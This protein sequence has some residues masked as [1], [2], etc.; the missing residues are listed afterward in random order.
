VSP[1]L[2]FIGISCNNPPTHLIL[3]LLASRLT[4]WT[5][6]STPCHSVYGLCSSHC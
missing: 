4:L 3:S 5:Q 2:A 6:L 1:F